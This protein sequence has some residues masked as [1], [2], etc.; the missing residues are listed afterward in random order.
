M[1]HIVYS[2]A[3]KYVLAEDYSD[4]APFKPE[5]DIHV[6]YG[7]LLAN[8]D[9]K[10][11]KGFLFS[12]NSPAINTEDS[13][14]AACCHDFF[15]SL[16]K[17]GSLSRDYREAVDRLFYDHLIQDSMIGL[18]AWYWYKAVRIG[19]DAALDSPWPK[20]IKAPRDESLPAGHQLRDVLKV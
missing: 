4:K 7:H 12:A 14:R 11:A 9:Y 15:Y 13:K 17:D 10:I 2:H 16:M 20:K 5:I 18:R 6:S 3:D 8:G 1:K 19:G